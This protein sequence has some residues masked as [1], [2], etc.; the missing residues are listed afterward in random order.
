M[1]AVEYLKSLR[2]PE[3]DLWLDPR[4]PQARAFVSHAHSDH[5]GRHE[6]TL[7]TAPTARL[8]EVRMGGELGAFE[9]LPFGERRDFG[10][11]S[12]TF[13][14]AGH[15][16]G[17]AQFLYESEQG[18][19]LY[20]GDFKLRA[21][22]SSE[23]AETPQAGTLVME[24]TFGL[25]RYQFPPAEETTAA[26]LKF[27]LEAIEDG[28]TPVLLGYALGKAQEILA[29][30]G[31]AGLPIMLH[32]AVW[33]IT[34]VYEEF[35]L[36]FPPH[37]KYDAARVAG[38]VIVAPPNVNGSRMLARIRNRRVAVL[39][40]WAMDPSAVHR[41]QVD[42][43]FPLS[44]HADY[45]D[46]WKFVE[47]VQPQRVLTLHGY[48]REFARDLRARGIEAWAL[49][50]ANQLELAID[51]SPVTVPVVFEA[52]PVADEGFPRFCA[53]CE[54]IRQTTGKLEKVRILAEYLRSLES[55]DLPLAAT[56]LTGRA[57]AQSDDRP[58]Q[59]GWAVIHRALSLAS[60]LAPTEIRAIA[61][62][63]NDS[64][65]TAMEV[66]SHRPGGE[67]FAL[68]GIDRLLQGIRQAR[69]PLAKTD[70][71]AEDL[72]ALTPLAAGY[73]VRI[74]T[75][76]LRIG[77]KEG[78]VE[79][80][81]AAAFEA[82]AVAV[83]EANMLLGDM[84]RTA[85]L[86]RE[87][88]LDEA[89]LS[90]FR[91]IKCMLASPEPDSESIW[92]RLGA[93]GSVWIEDKLD[94]IR[95]QL[96]VSPDRVEIYSRDLK[97]ITG[98]FPEIAAAALRLRRQAVFDGEILAWDKGRALS[99]F[100]L[101]KRLG[102]RDTDLFFVESDIPVAI[103]VFDL[104]Q[105]DGRSLLKKPLIERRSL[106]ERLPLAGTLAVAAVQTVRSAD[107]IEQ[108]FRAAR[109]RGNEG[110]MAK[111]PTSLYSPGRRGLAWLKL[112]KEFATLDVVVV[113][114]EY[115]HGRRSKVLSDYT[116][117]VRDDDS[118]ALLTIGKAYS[119]VT[120]AEIEELT[121]LFLR[122][123]I[124][125]KG[126]FFSVEPRVVLEV[127]FDSIQPSSRHP[128]GL[129][130][131]FPRIKQIRRDKTPDEIDTLAAARSLLPQ[132]T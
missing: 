73:L 70:L 27:C 19:L 6:Y 46:L 131:R 72:R 82:E 65:L 125:R 119:G 44:D 80:A 62:R 112:K 97:R 91:P 69:G 7:C 75:G 47:A 77:L 42:A 23:H 11:W 36:R 100:E 52:P 127:A 31:G 51:E 35:G 67:V 83:R 49:T 76:D 58:L 86:A 5:T 38:H 96:H 98:T 107:E 30:L 1:V 113:G 115:G 28:E 2:L 121:E 63:H 95:A 29:V 123:A 108:A 74:L 17:S 68:R 79:E 53:V 71:L 99:F 34:K 64:G 18:T 129:S 25:P 128:S 4:Q 16:L 24:T 41:L 55:T 14:P 21:G 114:A 56:W 10:K 88:R 116:F 54:S 105:L 110:L 103:Q 101:Q 87:K 118:G 57:F 45:P 39:T 92:E 9:I 66:M 8:M 102:R 132:S 117:A 12:A 50:G 109:H 122:I 111:D 60:G 20:T 93:S 22:L 40:G 3:A 33:N 120:D 59:A 32:G 43:A 126:N 26:V 130:L 13:V 78:L 89:E 106:L 85:V 94:G 104:L 61:R 124:E 15:V 90:L 84:G 81:V 48:A 37:E